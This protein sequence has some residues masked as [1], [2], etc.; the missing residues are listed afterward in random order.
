M[1]KWRKEIQEGTIQ[2]V[3]AL[4]YS[5]P[6][7][8]KVVVLDPERFAGIQNMKLYHDG[9]ILSRR[10]VTEKQEIPVVR[11][12]N[13]DC[14]LE[15]LELKNQGFNPVVLNMASARKPG[16]GYKAGAGAQEENLF[17]R[18]NLFQYHEPKRDDWYPIP[19]FG[20]IYCPNALVIRGSEQ[21]GYEWLEVPETMSF[22]AVAAVKNPK[23]VKDST[24]D[25]TLTTD[26]K[27]STR[28]KI[29][30]I[31]NI[32]LEN[33]HD[34]IVLSAFGCG[35]Y[36]NPPRTMAQLFYEVLSNEYAGGGESL[37]CTYRHISFAIF[38][39]ANTSKQHNPNGNLYPFEQKFAKG[40]A[41]GG[42][43]IVDEPKPQ[44]NSQGTYQFG[45]NQNQRQ[46][47]KQSIPH[48]KEEKRENRNEFRVRRQPHPSSSSSSQYKSS[49]DNER[50]NISGSKGLFSSPRSQM[51]KQ[52]EPLQESRFPT[53]TSSKGFGHGGSSPLR[54]SRKYRQTTLDRWYKPPL[55]L[56]EQF[57]EMGFSKPDVEHALKKTNGDIDRTLKLLSQ[58]LETNGS[59]KKESTVE[60]TRSI[61]DNDSSVISKL[62][63]MELDRENP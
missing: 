25:F 32:G 11:V 61:G 57:I 55:V 19:E 63:E 33:G 58:P 54:F 40:L 62:S 30:T 49:G 3:K 42:V 15:A 7:I 16:G 41:T 12:V 31:L 53:V 56:I 8:N 39:D 36:S 23:I 13:G 51:A 47:G 37:P 2:A 10:I 6:K 5:I 1:N 9:S 20:G 28:K 14:L 59:N 29:K 24:G 22:V 43:E 18:T 48:D 45:N 38:D 60:L 17:R 26:I 46:H 27:E 52:G 44:R 34:A 50:G 21:E 4:R 35:A